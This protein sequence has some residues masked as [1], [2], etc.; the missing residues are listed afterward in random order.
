MIKTELTNNQ[1]EQEVA[2]LR[3]IY[4]SVTVHIG[5]D[6]YRKNHN[7]NYEECDMDQSET[8]LKRAYFHF[9]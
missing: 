3:E 2:K 5:V 1:I 7:G 6:Y 8:S 9:E 4:K